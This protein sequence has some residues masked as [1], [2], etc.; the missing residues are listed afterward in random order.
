MIANTLNLKVIYTSKILLSWK[1]T[2]VII[3]MK[4]SIAWMHFLTLKLCF[5]LHNRDTFC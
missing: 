3:I 1:Q 2:K 4:K 5:L